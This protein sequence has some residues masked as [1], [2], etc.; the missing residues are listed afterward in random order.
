MAT[1]TLLKTLRYELNNK[2]KD[3]TLVMRQLE[4]VETAIQKLEHELEHE[5]QQI[6]KEP[7]LIGSYGAYFERM[8]QRKQNLLHNK[9]ALSRQL[10]ALEEEIRVCFSEIKKYE[11]LHEQAQKAKRKKLSEQE[12]AA[13]DDMSMMNFIRQ[14]E[15]A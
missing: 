1:Q 7:L 4:Q 13:A 6:H 15:H 11:I 3:V 9:Q 8:Q 14:K 2:R 5:K 12:Q 10:Q